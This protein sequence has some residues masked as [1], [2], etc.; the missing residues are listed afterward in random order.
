MLIHGCGP[1]PDASDLQAIWLEA[2]AAG[3]ARDSTEML[4]RFNEVL[5]EFVYYADQTG[6][7]GNPDF[8]PALDLEN[9]RAALAELK[10]LNRSRDFRRRQYDAL[11]G[12]T[13]FKEFVMDAGAS[14][15]VGGFLL[16]HKQP[17][18]A[19]Y[20]AGEQWALD[21]RTNLADRIKRSLEAGE[22]LLL[23]AHCLGSVLA[24]DVLWHLS[25]EQAVAGRVTFVTLGSPLG[26]RSVQRRLLGRREEGASKY[27]NNISLWHNLSAEDD[28]VC[29]DKTV[30]DDF[31]TMLRY[32]LLGDIRDFTIYNLSVRYGRSNTHSSV[33][34][35]IHPRMT[36]LL[37][38]WLG[39]EP[40]SDTYCIGAFAERA[41]TLWSYK[42]LPGI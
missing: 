11:P 36:K 19:S 40:L 22:D 8:D 3:L 23:V 4:S 2:L 9:R 32:K 34:Y 27:P 18:L 10:K 26:D 5:T 15:G 25:R 28:Y 24:Y 31:K 29:H 6:V 21:L 20:L 12:K 38:E 1:K 39:A 16:E 30:A 7:A 14:L 17:E 41:R 37:S 35:L 13:A 33:G 42:T